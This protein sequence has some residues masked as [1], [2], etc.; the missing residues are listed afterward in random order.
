MRLFFT[1]CALSNY[2]ILGTYTL[3]AYSQYPPPSETTYIRIDAQLVEWYDKTVGIVLDHNLVLPTFGAFQGHPKAGN[4]WAEKVITILL[5]MG[6]I[7]TCHEFC[8]YDGSFKGYAV[9]A[10]RQ[11]D[12]LIFCGKLETILQELVMVLAKTIK[13]EM[14]PE[15]MNNYN[16]L[17]VVHSHAYIKVHVSPYIGNILEWNGWSYGKPSSYNPIETIHPSS[18]KELETTVGLEDQCEAQRLEKEDGFMY[19][20]ATEKLINTY[21]TCHLDT[22]FVMSELCKFN[23]TP[24]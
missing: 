4:S 21:A 5:V 15:L 17:E 16:W 10:C 6:F 13:I 23:N 1:I 7:N 14:E 20:T 22:S 9:F 11:V 2:F 18:L 19:R 12:E 8:I 24:S 3:N